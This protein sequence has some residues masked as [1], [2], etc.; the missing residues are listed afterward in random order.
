MKNALNKYIPISL[1]LF[2]YQR[3]WLKGDLIAGMVV[4]VVLIPQGMAYA[5][6]AGIDPIYGLYTALVPP[7]VYSIFGSARQ[8]SPGPVA[9]DSLLVM[10]GV[11]AI[12]ESEKNLKTENKH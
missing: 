9:M 3:S 10:T 1:W 5:L 8:I 2:N 7:V 11:S 6:I 12:A 4:C